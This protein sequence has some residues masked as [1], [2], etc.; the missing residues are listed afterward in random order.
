MPAQQ[1]LEAGD[2]GR[3]DGGRQ[4]LPHERQLAAWRGLMQVA[5]Q[6][7]KLTQLVVHLGTE[8]DDLVLARPLRLVERRVGVV[9]QRFRILPV[10][11]VQPDPDRGRHE[12]V[13]L[14][15]AEIV[16]GT[17]GFHQ[18]PG[19]LARLVE[20][21]DV[22]LQDDEL[23]ASEA[24]HRAR[25]AR[26]PAESRRHLAEQPVADAMAVHVVD[27]LETI[28]VEAEDGK[29]AA[30]RSTQGD[31]LDDAPPAAMSGWRGP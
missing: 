25:V 2:L 28:Q 12:A 10:G 3:V 29:P 13:H 21:H 26:D 5:L 8:E 7:S 27:G 23:V 22:R 18:A 24:R 11:G 20:L 14:A 6:G 15:D 30:A 1:H 9:Q 4:G 31:R 19:H 17:E 16:G